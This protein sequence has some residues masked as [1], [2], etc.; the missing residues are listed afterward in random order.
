MLRITLVFMIALILSC[1]QDGESFNSAKQDYFPLVEGAVLKYEGMRIIEGDW[2]ELRYP[3]TATLKIEDVA[4]SGDTQIATVRMDIDNP[5]I[6]VL[7][8]WQ[9][10][11]SP[12]NIVI[13][14]SNSQPSADDPYSIGVCCGDLELARLPLRDNVN[15]PWVDTLNSVSV[16]G[17]SVWQVLI[18][19]FQEYETENKEFINCSVIEVNNQA[20]EDEDSVFYRL[21]ISP[22]KGLVGFQQ[23]IEV[24]Q[25]DIYT[26]VI[27]EFRL[28]E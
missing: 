2:L 16:T 6:G 19:H 13:K 3:F 22:S 9:I 15:Q 25:Y 17:K 1:T 10:I 8:E 14:A 24:K 27:T 20:N 4:V 18:T 26:K 28:A 7:N 5:F 23:V 12:N 21:F 11:K